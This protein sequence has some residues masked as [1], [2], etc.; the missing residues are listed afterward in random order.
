LG[1]VAWIWVWLFYGVSRQEKNIASLPVAFGTL[2]ALLL[3]VLFWSRMRWRVRLGLAGSVLGII[4]LSVATLKIRGVS[5]D[6]VPILEW[7]WSHR[8]LSLPKANGSAPAIPSEATRNEYP[9]FLG[10]DRTGALRGPKL[11]RDWQAQPPVQLWRQSVGAAWSGFSVSGPFAITQEQ[12][13]DDECVVCYEVLT[14]QVF[15]THADKARYATTIAGEGPRATPTIVGTRVFT[16]G[17][18]GLLN[19]LD[20]ATG[21]KIWSKNIV[22]ENQSKLGDWG[23][24]GSPLAVGSLIIV[25]AGGKTDRSLVAYEAATGRFVWGSGKSSMDYSSPA[26]ARIAGAEQILIFNPRN[27]AAHDVTTGKILWNHPW[28]GSHPHVT[29]PIVLPDDRVLISSGYGTGAELVKVTNGDPWSATRLWKSNRLKSKFANLIFHDGFIYGLDDGIMVCLD[30]ADGALQWKEGRYGHGQMILVGDVLLIMAEAG[31][32]A[33]IE[34]SPSGLRELTRFTVF[35][36]KTWNPPALAGD[37]LLVRNDKEAACY[38]LP[39]ADK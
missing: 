20:L 10:P 13:S 29:I 36:D 27:V 12:R 18:T 24:A 34:P 38:R 22:Q 15:W 23:V 6:L 19:C 4:G 26:L 16:Q 39:L 8:A 30:P 25:S 37:L 35:K 32:V 5:G 17:A 7:R 33:L 21:R 3:W 1:G 31:N 2:V 11:A 9:Q 28:P 14:G